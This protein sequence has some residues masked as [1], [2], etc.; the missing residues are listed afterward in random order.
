MQSGFHFKSLNTL[1]TIRLGSLAAISIQGWA[2]VG[3]RNLWTAQRWPAAAC[4]DGGGLRGKRGAGS[5]RDIHEGFPK[6]RNSLFLVKIHIWRPSQTPGICIFR[7][8]F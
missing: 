2:I 8:I 1:L 5:V 6:V 4:Q 3:S 7:I